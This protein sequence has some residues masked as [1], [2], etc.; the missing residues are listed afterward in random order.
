MEDGRKEAKV[1]VIG[2]MGELRTGVSK[3]KCRSRHSRERVKGV[4]NGG[5]FPVFLK[6]IY[7]P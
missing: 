5:L 3:I 2:V 4:A 6:F 7:L 1:K